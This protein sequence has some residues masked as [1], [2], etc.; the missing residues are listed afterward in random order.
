MFPLK[1]QSKLTAFTSQLCYRYTGT[2]FNVG[3]HLRSW[4]LL[5]NPT[6]RYG[7]SLF[8]FLYLSVLL[9]HRA[10]RDADKCRAKYG[11][12]YAK[13]AERVKYLVIPYVF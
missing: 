11:K 3:P 7:Q 4:G 1:V 6:L 5:T 8:Y 10:L 13:Y 2:K 12:D 9:L